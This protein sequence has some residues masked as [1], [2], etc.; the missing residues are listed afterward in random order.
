MEN[1]YQKLKRSPMERNTQ[2]HGNLFKIFCVICT[3]IPS[4]PCG[5]FKYIIMLVSK[6]KHEKTGFFEIYLEYIHNFSSQNGKKQITKLKKRKPYNLK[7][8]MTRTQ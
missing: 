8:M 6:L 7:Q 3:S 5:L 4:F 2:T 1:S